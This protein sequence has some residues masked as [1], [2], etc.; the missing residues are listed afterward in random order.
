MT[1]YGDNSTNLMLYTNYVQEKDGTIRPIGYA[2][3]KPWVEQALLM[4]DMSFDTPEEAK[5]WWEKNYGGGD[6]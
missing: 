4:G 6:K 3:G 1:T 5:A 2:Y